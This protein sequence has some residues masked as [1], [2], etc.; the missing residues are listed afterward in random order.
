[1]KTIAVVFDRPGALALRK[2]ALP[3]PTAAD[4]IVEHAWSGVSTGTE[5]LLFRGEMPAF[6]GL[7]YPLVPGYESVGRVIHAGAQ[8]GAAEGDLVFVPGARCF[9][10]ARCLFG[11]TARHVV[12][13]GSRVAMAPHASGADAALLALAATAFHAI[14]DGDRIPDLVVGHG[15]LGR[16]VA[17][18]VIALG[19][20]APRVW[21]RLAMRRSGAHGY[22]VIDP[23]TDPHAAYQCIVD[24]SGDPKAVTQLV[25][26]LAPRGELVLG[27]FYPE[28]VS[29]DFPTAFMRRA[30]LRVAAEWEPADLTAVIALVA[31]GSLSLA[32]I[33]SHRVPA[34]E[35]PHAYQTAF[36][37]PE[38]VKLVLDWSTCA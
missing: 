21:E 24:V 33:V 13:H 8:S 20:P 1:M 19:H 17:R 31:D 32:G 12:V 9:T 15:A 4:V 10:D 35:A 23:D 34:T 22:D 2:L 11:G 3:E 6:P 7:G 26:R 27:G 28:P 25:G 30:R 18:L 29:F 16:L 38:C 14:C 37:S 5:R 36:D